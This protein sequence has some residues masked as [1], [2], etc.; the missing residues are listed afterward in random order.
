MSSYFQRNELPIVELLVFK[1]IIHFLLFETL[2]HNSILQEKT[3]LKWTQ[4]LG[5]KIEIPNKKKEK[6]KD[7]R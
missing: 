2:W 6:V 1:L 5:N 7:K 3:S 4:S